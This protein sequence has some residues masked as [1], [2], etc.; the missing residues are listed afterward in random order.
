LPKD[1]EEY[2]E[3]KYEYKQVKKQLKQWNK[4][5]DQ[6]QTDLNEEEFE[7]LRQYKSLMRKMKK[8][9]EKAHPEWKSERKKP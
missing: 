3:F 6:A 2:Q 5:A 1:Q 4:Q 9:T 7:K 8:A